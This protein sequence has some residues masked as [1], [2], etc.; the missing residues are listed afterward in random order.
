VH[1]LLLAVVSF[2]ENLYLVPLFTQ[3]KIHDGL[4]ALLLSLEESFI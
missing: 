1:V 4:E 2:E 3:A